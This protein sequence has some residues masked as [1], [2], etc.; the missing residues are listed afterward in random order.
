MKKCDG[1]HGPSVGIVRVWVRPELHGFRPGTE[2]DVLIFVEDT[3]LA[4]LEVTV[5]VV[6]SNSG[7]AMDTCASERAKPVHNFF[8]HLPILI[9]AR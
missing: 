2:L 6:A 3:N 7:E 5:E 4:M 9:T 8:F 1:S